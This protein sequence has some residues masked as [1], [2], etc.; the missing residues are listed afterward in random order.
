[1]GVA[2]FGPWTIF[3]PGMVIGG[4]IGNV[5][6]RLFRSGNGFLRGEVIDFIDL[7]WWPVFNVADIAITVGG[8]L[9]IGNAWRRGSPRSPAQASSSRDG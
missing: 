4:A 5:C 3:I 7:Q 9:L 8:V 1:M 2:L 6:D